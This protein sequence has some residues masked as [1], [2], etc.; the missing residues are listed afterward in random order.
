VAICVLAIRDNELSVRDDE[1][2]LLDIAKGGARAGKLREVMWM[3][4]DTE[5]NM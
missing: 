2:A 4:L 5:Q 3:G 1:D